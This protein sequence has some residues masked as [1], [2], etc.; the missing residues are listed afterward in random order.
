MIEFKIVILDEKNEIV[1]WENGQ[2]RF[3]KP[4]H[5]EIIL[6]MTE[7]LAD[8]NMLVLQVVLPKELYSRI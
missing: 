3:F 5:Y 2:N 7:G 1:R 6:N 4:V 8:L